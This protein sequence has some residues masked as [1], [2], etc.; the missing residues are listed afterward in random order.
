MAVCLVEQLGYVVALLSRD[1]SFI[2]RCDGTATEYD[3]CDVRPPEYDVHRRIPRVSNAQSGIERFRLDTKC[4]FV[5]RTR[6]DAQ[7][8]L[9]ARGAKRVLFTDN[10]LGTLTDFE[11][12]DVNE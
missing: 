1:Y 3:E 6:Y 11:A 8:S 12:R 5:W 4:L 2:H 9:F 7:Y 10:E